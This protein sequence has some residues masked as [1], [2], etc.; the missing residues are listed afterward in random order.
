MGGAA[1]QNPLRPRGAAS[2]PWVA[3]GRLPCREQRGHSAGLAPS[4]PGPG[5]AGAA[6]SWRPEA[7]VC[8]QHMAIRPLSFSL[9]KAELPEPQS[10]QAGALVPVAHP[11]RATSGPSGPAPVRSLLGLAPAPFPPFP[12]P[13]QATVA[14]P[15]PPQIS[16]HCDGAGWEQ[17]WPYQPD[18]SICCLGTESTSLLGPPRPRVVCPHR[19]RQPHCSPASSYSAPRPCSL[20]GKRE[21]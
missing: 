9:N 4:P 5:P 18:A 3:V 13:V 8:L 6:F 16:L 14:A 15:P 12:L 7:G 17:L 10:T 2:C 19:P 1:P 21:E 11:A 20:E